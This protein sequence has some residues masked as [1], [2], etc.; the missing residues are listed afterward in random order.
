[1][2]GYLLLNNESEYNQLQTLMLGITNPN[3]LD[4]KIF[5][6]WQSDPYFIMLIDTT[7]KVYIN[8][9]DWFNAL[10]S[11]VT[12][13]MSTEDLNRLVSGSLEAG[14]I[15]LEYLPNIRSYDYLVAEGYL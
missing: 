2:V 3:I 13:L 5:M 14:H 12:P 8:N 1:M 4:Q 11:Y 9:M 15:K 10:V 6:G 7:F